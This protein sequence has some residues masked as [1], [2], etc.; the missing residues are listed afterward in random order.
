M[1][2][3][4]VKRRRRLQAKSDILLD[5]LEATDAFTSLITR[6]AFILWKTFK[7]TG[8]LIGNSN[9]PRVIH[10]SVIRVLSVCSC[11]HLMLVTGER[12]VAIKF[13]MHHPYITTRE[14]IKAAVISYW[15]VCLA[16]EVFK[17]FELTDI[18]SF[19]S[20]TVVLSSCIVFVASAFPVLYLETRRHLKRTKTQ[21]MSQGEAERFLKDNKALK[22]TVC[23]VVFA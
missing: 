1:V 20:I 3:S 15:I 12:L 23:A 8:V 5:C 16:S 9:P 4:V 2:I 17:F 13:T 10:S 19:I 6:S 21:Q 14:N 11:L 7:L 22:T 18:I